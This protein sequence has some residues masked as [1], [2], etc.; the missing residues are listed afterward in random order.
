MTSPWA[1]AQKC[2]AARLLV[3][4]GS[5]ASLQLCGKQRL[6]NSESTI[7]ILFSTVRA[8]ETFTTSC[9]SACVAHQ[10]AIAAAMEWRCA[11]DAPTANAEQKRSIRMWW[12]PGPSL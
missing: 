3:R 7:E 1:G 6:S 4:A 9:R 10:V 11:R 2:G 12:L 5:W 8:L